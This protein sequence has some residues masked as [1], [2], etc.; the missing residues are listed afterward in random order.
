[1][2]ATGDKRALLV[3]DMINPLDFP[4]GTELQRQAIPIARNIARLKHRLKQQDV[5]V[6]YVNDN[7]THWLSDFRELVAICSQPDVLGAPLAH[8][9]PPEHDDYLVLKPKHSGFFASPLEVLLR[10]LEVRHV[11][12]TGIAGDGCVLNTAADAHMREFQVTVPSDC[13]ASITPQRNASALRLM[14]ASMRLSTPS[15][16]RL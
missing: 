8:A 9:L 14:K 12:V 16:R 10:Q 13:C 15:S 2:T 3:I 7:F 5:P 6:I 1:M 4:G 11:I